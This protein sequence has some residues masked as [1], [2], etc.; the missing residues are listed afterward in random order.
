M[1]G[2]VWILKIH[3][4]YSYVYECF[5]YMYTACGLGP[6]DTQKRASDPLELELRMLMNKTRVLCQSNKF[7]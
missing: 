3:L 1:D 7:S 2:L 4:L 5:A 6:A